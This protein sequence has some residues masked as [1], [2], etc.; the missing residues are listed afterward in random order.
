MHKG[1]GTAVGLTGQ[2]FCWIRLKSGGV[3]ASSDYLHYAIGTVGGFTSD[4][5]SGGGPNAF[6]VIPNATSVVVNVVAGSDDDCLYV[7]KT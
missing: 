3:N 4:V 5:E 6:I 7:F 2:T 1:S